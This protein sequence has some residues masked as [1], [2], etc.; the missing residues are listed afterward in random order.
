MSVVVGGIGEKTPKNLVL[1]EGDL[2]Y[3]A[4]KLLYCYIIRKKIHEMLR[5]QSEFEEICYILEVKVLH[6]KLCNWQILC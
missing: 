2:T 5:S 3:C 1:I 4:R 6:L